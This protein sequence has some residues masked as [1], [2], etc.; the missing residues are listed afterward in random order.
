M[1]FVYLRHQQIVTAD[2]LNLT[3]LGMTKC[4]RSGAGTVRLQAG[5]L[6]SGTQAGELRG[7]SNMANWRTYHVTAADDGGRRVEVEHASRASSTHENKAND[8]VYSHSI[9]WHQHPAEPTAPAGRR[10]GPG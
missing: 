4:K 6:R 1:H 10:R 5:L 8:D 3:A 9:G 7:A 2:E